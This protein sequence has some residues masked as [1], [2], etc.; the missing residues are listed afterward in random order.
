M[1][2]ATVGLW[3]PCLVVFF[4]QKTKIGKQRR[5]E[6][7]KVEQISGKEEDRYIHIK[8]CALTS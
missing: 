8:T 3:R 6:K 1:Q 7:K 5:K 4:S 2:K